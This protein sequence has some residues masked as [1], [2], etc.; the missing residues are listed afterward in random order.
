MVGYHYLINMHG[1]EKDLLNDAPALLQVLLTAARDA[2]AKVLAHNTVS[3]TPQG[4]TAFVVV[5]E[6]H[7]S[8]HTWPEKRS[9]YADVF[10]CG[11][12]EMTR[13]ATQVILDHLNPCG[14]TIECVERD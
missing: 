13:I 14:H 2:G 3:F 4:V 10:T 9:A 1:C 5:A 6:S 8:I 12:E 11:T 7:L